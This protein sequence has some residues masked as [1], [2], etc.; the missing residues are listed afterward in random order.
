[1]KSI[2]IITMS[3]IFLTLFGCSQNQEHPAQTT[4]ANF[5]KS[6][7]SISSTEQENTTT[8]TTTSIYNVD[9]EISTTKSPSIPSTKPTTNTTKTSTQKY[10]PSDEAND[11]LIYIKKGD[12]YYID[13][14]NFAENQNNCY[15]IPLP[16]YFLNKGIS[17][18]GFAVT[19][20]YDSKNWMITSSKGIY[21][22]KLVG[23]ETAVMTAPKD[24]A[25]GTFNVPS[26]DD[27][28]KIETVGF[29]SQQRTLF[30]TDYAKHWWSNGYIQSEIQN[31][32][33]I[34][35]RNKI[36]FKNEEMATLFVS[37]LHKHRLSAVQSE[38]D[39]T[40]NHYYVNGN[41][42]TYQF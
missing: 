42:V 33:E 31:P 30:S 35:V 4:T 10:V 14:R 20:T 32:N 40:E 16:N 24:A 38:Q 36:T 6:E 7:S 11:T 29:D 27:W 17:L 13:D 39:L 23:S 8:P 37:E 12:M 21:G 28:L 34:T 2:K 1:M 18:D 5:S 22:H 41:D 9:D 3:L 19:F 15:G 26:E 25:V